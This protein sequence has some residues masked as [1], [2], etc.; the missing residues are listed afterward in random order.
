[1]S[2]ASTRLEKQTLRLQ[3]APYGFWL[4]GNSHLG[5]LSLS[6]LPTIRVFIK[7]SGRD[8]KH[9]ARDN[10]TTCNE[11]GTTKANDLVDEDTQC[12]TSD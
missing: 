7:L 9:D 3:M 4:P 2:S 10:H 12:P 5:A 1:M 8:T 11:R 6:F